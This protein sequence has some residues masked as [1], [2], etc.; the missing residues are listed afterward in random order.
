MGRGT[1]TASK[2]FL[3]VKPNTASNLKPRSSEMPQSYQRPEINPNNGKETHPAY[4]LI[5]VSRPQSSPGTNLFGS[6][7]SHQHFIAVHIQT[8]AVDR[9]LSR[10]WVYPEEHVLEF[11]MSEAQWAKFVAGGGRS[12]ATPITLSHKIKGTE[13]EVLPAI[14]TKEVNRKDQF[15]QEFKD[16]L[17]RQLGE[18]QELAKELSTLSEQKS[19]SKVQLRQIS[20]NLTN[21]LD[22]LPKNVDFMVESFKEVT[23]TVVEEAK[24]EVEAYVLQVQQ[25]AGIAALQSVPEPNSPQ[26]PSFP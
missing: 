15:N 22:N 21:K 11:Y 20:A 8:A 7:L 5:S 26:L 1:E 12:Q 14:P 2:T 10:D 6:D 18:I 16:K 3:N 24:A 17:Q 4:G 19:V 25:S 13:L 9:S 23:E